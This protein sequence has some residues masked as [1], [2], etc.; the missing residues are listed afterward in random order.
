MMEELSYSQKAIHAVCKGKRAYCKFLWATDTECSNAHQRRIS[1]DKKAAPILF[2]SP[3]VR[4]ENKTKAVTITWQDD[5]V[6]E[7]VFAYYGKGTQNDY[8]I[9]GFNRDF[10]LLS[11]DHT[12]DLFVL[13]QWDDWQYSAYVLSTEDDIDAFLGVYGMSPAETDA[14][15][16]A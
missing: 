16:R 14:L 3:G 6:T 9:T 12:G 13:V 11:P 10:P 4:G 15:I 7:A 2:D 8:W 5:W 1:I